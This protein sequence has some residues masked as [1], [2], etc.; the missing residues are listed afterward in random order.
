VNLH[1]S[2]LL[3]P[4][5]TAWVGRHDWAGIVV[6]VTEHEIVRDWIG[7]GAAL[8][9]LRHRGARIS[10]D[11]AGAGFSSLRQVILFRPDF[12]KLD[13]ELTAGIDLDPARRALA[14][15]LRGFALELGAVV[16]AERIETEAEREVVSQIGI[17]YGQGYLLGRPGP[18]DGTPRGDA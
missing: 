3:T 8:D 2:T 10:V 16:I 1:P 18:Y 6:E 17:P 13:G 11:D 12:I 15:A 7:V 5:W 9:D 4:Q 14:T